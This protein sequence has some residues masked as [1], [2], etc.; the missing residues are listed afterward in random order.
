MTADT[1]IGALADELRADPGRPLVTYYDSVGNRVELSVATFANWAA[2]I[3]NLLTHELFVEPGGTVSV[4][5]PQH[6]QG[7]VAVM[8]AWT[9]GL[10][11]TNDP[12]SPVDVRVV[13]APGQEAPSVHPADQV[14]ATSLHPLGMRVTAALPNGWLDFG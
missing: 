6:W 10:S 8:G 3:A 12:A 1:A 13:A 11:L 9:A 14:I 2:K 4:D 7:S 5:L